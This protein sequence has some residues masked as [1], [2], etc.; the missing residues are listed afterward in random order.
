MAHQLKNKQN[1]TAPNSTFPFG[2]IKDNP[3]NNTGTPY[4]RAVYGDFHQF[5]AKSL[6]DSGIT[7]NDLDENAVNGFQYFNALKINTRPFTTAINATSFFGAYN[8][9]PYYA[10]TPELAYKTLFK[11]QPLSSGSFIMNLPQCSSLLDCAPFSAVHMGVPDGIVVITPFAGDNIA[12]NATFI[13]TKPGDCVQLVCDHSNNTWYISSTN[14]NR[15]SIFTGE[16]VYSGATTNLI[17]AESG[18]I[19]IYNGSGAGTFNLWALTNADSCKKITIFNSEGGGELTI[20]TPD[21]YVPLATSFIL[22]HGDSIELEASFSASPFAPCW[23]ILA[24]NRRN[25]SKPIVT[26]SLGA[27]W[28]GTAKYYCDDAGW[29]HLSGTLT[30]TVSTIPY[31]SPF[32]LNPGYRPLAAKKIPAVIDDSYLGVMQPSRIDITTAGVLS[33]IESN[34]TNPNTLTVFLDG[35]SFYKGW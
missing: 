33:L 1:V 12:G 6:A 25:Q 26:A 24:V 14:I 8:T 16:S 22:E 9:G 23:N 13:L 5:F 2:D 30:Y 10:A 17:A 35:I 15:G 11:A 18:N 28:S 29:V 34:N 27:G 20:N 3:G 32:T 31:V 4:N 7:P 19:I 21:T